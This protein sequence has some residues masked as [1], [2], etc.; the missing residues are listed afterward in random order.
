MPG[1]GEAADPGARD[2][3]NLRHIVLGVQARLSE[4]VL[5]LAMT[6][7]LDGY[8]RV[9]F[10]VAN[11]GGAIPMLVERLDHVSAVRFPDAPL[12][13]TRLRRL[14]VDTATFGPRGIARAAEVFG[15]DRV[16]LGTDCP[17]FE[18]GRTLDAV[19]ASG[20]AAAQIDGVLRTNGAALLEAH[21]VVGGAEPEA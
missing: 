6:D 10:Q 17:I 19:M 20:L 8:P 18:T 13:S 16:L 1:V 11:L 5:T 7:L 14:Y 2:N 9:T 12:P 4:V 15:A 3:D 21:P